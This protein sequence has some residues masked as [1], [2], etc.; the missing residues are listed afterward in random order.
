MSSANKQ[1]DNVTM[2]EGGSYSLATKGAKDVIDIA[3][4][5]VLQAVEGIS[6]L[7]DR[8]TIADMGCADAGTSL[9]MIRSAI[10]HVQELNPQAQTTVVYADQPANDFNALIGIVHGRTAAFDSWLGKIDNAYALASG[11]SFY[12]QA[13]PDQTLDLVFS[14]TAMHWLS[15]KPCNIDDHVHMVGASGDAL[16]QFSAQAKKDW[17]NILMCRARELKLGGKMVLINFCR[18]EQ[19]RYL[20]GTSGVNMFDNFNNNWL[21]FLQQERIS[22]DEYKAMTLPQYYHTVGQFSAPL[23]DHS[24][25]CYQAGLRLDDIE[26]RVVPCPF[27]VQYEKDGDVQSFADG[28]IPTV[29]SWNQSIFKA[30]LSNDRSEAERTQ[31]IEDYYATYHQQVMDD[32]VGHGMDYVHAYMTISRQ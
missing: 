1:A 4:P 24:N 7:D 3:T 28:L 17:E 11:A 6:P 12:L 22:A 27:R 21:A 26:T 31:L 14:A 25:P 18:D 23:L 20:G 8:V 16:E 30:G 10:V 2:S 13:V 5:R 9:D 29:R 32:P 19:G 15:S